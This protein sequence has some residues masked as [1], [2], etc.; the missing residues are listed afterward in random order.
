MNTRQLRKRIDKIQKVIAPPSGDSCTFQEL[1]QQIWR[2]D[3][4]AF[5]KLADSTHMP[6][7]LCIPGLRTPVPG[8]RNNPRNGH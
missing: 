7:Y 5:W 8:E 2:Q 3:K 6:L 4:K 1:V